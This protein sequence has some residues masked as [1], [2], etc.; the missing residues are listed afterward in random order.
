MKILAKT[1]LLVN[2]VVGV[3]ID[4]SNLVQSRLPDLSRLNRVVTDPTQPQP[5]FTVEKEIEQIVESKLP[6]INLSQGPQTADETEDLP[7]QEDI[8][9]FVSIKV[10][11]LD[12]TENTQTKEKDD[13]LNTKIKDETSE[14]EL[15]LEKDSEALPV[16]ED[17]RDIKEDIRDIKEDIR[18]IESIKISDVDFTQ[19]TIR[20]EKE[21]SPNTKVND[22]SFKSEDFPS[23]ISKEKESEEL[24]VQEEIRE[25]VSIKISDLDLPQNTQNM[26][27]E[28]LPSTK[29]KDETSESEK[30]LKLPVEKESEV[31]PVEE[32]IRDIV[33]IKIS[34][35]DFTQNTIKTEKEDSANKKDNEGT[36][37]SESI[38]STDISELVSVKFPIIKF[39]DSSS[40][41]PATGNISELPIIT[42]LPPSPVPTE[43]PQ[44][45]SSVEKISGSTEAPIVTVSTSPR[46][47]NTEYTVK[48]SDLPLIIPTVTASSSPSPTEL[49]EMIT[50]V[51]SS[52][53]NRSSTTLSSSIMTSPTKIPEMKATVRPTFKVRSSTKP[54][55]IKKSTKKMPEKRTTVRQILRPTPASRVKS[56]SLSEVCRG[57]S[58]DL[59][60]YLR[61]HPTD[62]TKF[63]SCQWLGGER[64][65]SVEFITLMLMLILMLILQAPRHGVSSN[66][67]I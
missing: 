65:R 20:T 49:P 29:V 54:S 21:D 52:Q 30:P 8:R 53:K 12:F 3:K 62:C 60:R 1:I 48:V 11:T 50:S 63:V 39:L 43:M 25:F 56:P 64:F 37:E 51:R 34:D 67:A 35:I 31:L 58:A 18:D 5:E 28:D 4:I 44:T 13:A 33:S 2:F 45:T 14:S 6:A 10:S 22:D 24:P 15:P 32:D 26:D 61:P 38:V 59:S 19:N 40:S 16:K 17:I 66:C 46:E 55:S 47:T 23:V 36:S 9:D 57:V 41:E 7:V 42:T 27:K